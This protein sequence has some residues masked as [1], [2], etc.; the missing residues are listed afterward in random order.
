MIGAIKNIH[1]C[2]NFISLETGDV[3]LKAQKII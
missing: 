1:I 3:L 2:D